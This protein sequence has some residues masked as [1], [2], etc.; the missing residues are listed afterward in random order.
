MLS[1]FIWC[2][3][4][5]GPKLGTDDIISTTLMLTSPHLTLQGDQPWIKYV[6][7]LVSVC[8]GACTCTCTPRRP[9]QG[10]LCCDAWREGEGR[11]E[12][13]NS[14]PGELS[15]PGGE[16]ERE[17]NKINKT[18]RKL[19]KKK[20]KNTKTLKNKTKR[21]KQLQRWCQQGNSS[22]FPGC[23]PTGAEKEEPV[24]C[25]LNQNV[26]TDRF[27]RLAGRVPRKWALSKPSIQ[28]VHK[29]P[30]ADSLQTWGADFTRLHWYI[31]PQFIAIKKNKK[32]YECVKE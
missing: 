24:T 4:R 16:K 14:C 21:H 13:T 29:Q 31:Y 5:K 10:W 2:T 20:W 27:C 18:T 8:V 22:P 23:D 17:T 25:R 11:M 28:T 9:A 1:L 6:H 19:E 7:V 32:S 30:Q 26:Q 15:E 12:R 3:S